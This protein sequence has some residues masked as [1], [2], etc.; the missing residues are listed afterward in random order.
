MIIG[1]TP[2]LEAI[3]DL[4]EGKAL[5]GSGMRQERE[6]VD[7]ALDAAVSGQRV[8]LVSSGDAG[9]YG[10]AGIALERAEARDLGIA[11]EIVPGVTAASAAAARL[12]A[13]LMLD[14]ATISLSDLLVPWE[15]IAHRVACVAAADLVLALYNPRS[16]KRTRQLSEVRQILLQHRAAETPVGIAR[17]VGSEDETIA[18]STLGNFREDDVDMRSILIIGNSSTRANQ[19]WMLTPRGYYQ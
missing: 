18:L 5:R 1:Y 13:P 15:T 9:I 6:R 19:G 10:M 3:A 8:A 2:Y 12:G 17:A 16:H 7:A 11:I 14:Y 4:T